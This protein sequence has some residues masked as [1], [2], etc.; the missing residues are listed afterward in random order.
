MKKKKCLGVKANRQWTDS[1]RVAGQEDKDAEEPSGAGG[2]ADASKDK[3]GDGGGASK[4]EDA[5]KED[6]PA[7]GFLASLRGRAP[8]K[9]GAEGDPAAS[10][11]GKKRGGKRSSPS[12][13]LSGVKIKG[14][15]DVPTVL[16]AV[17]SAYLT[18]RLVNTVMRTL[19]GGGAPAPGSAG[20]ERELARVQQKLRVLRES[21]QELQREKASWLQAK[22]ALQEERAA[23]ESRHADTLRQMEATLETALSRNNAE[24]GQKLKAVQDEANGKL[25]QVQAWQEE[26]EKLRSEASQIRTLI[27]QV[28]SRSNSPSGRGRG[29]SPLSA[30]KENSL[31]SS[32]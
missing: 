12:A 8:G 18:G 5:A 21:E 7:P 29:Q 15:G 31:L 22:S 17:G 10:S 13:K 11:G 4:A 28:R 25:A 20:M 16:L 19:R 26:L 6:A 2:N 9:E 1:P 32:T 3:A 30:G 24:W 27:E 23:A 14:G